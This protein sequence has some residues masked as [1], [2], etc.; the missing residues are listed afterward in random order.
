[1][2]TVELAYPTGSSVTLEASSCGACVVT[3]STR[4]MREYVTDGATGRL[5]GVGDVDGWRD[6]LTTL[7][8]DDDER[9]RLG[10]GARRGVEERHNTRFMWRELD[11]VMRTRGVVT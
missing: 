3:S 6:T 11:D 10:A 9:A 7:L 5:V 2:P 4:S 8:A 1:M